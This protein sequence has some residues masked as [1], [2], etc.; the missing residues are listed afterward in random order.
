M[1]SVCMGIV[2]S[3]SV[4]VV[5]VVSV[6]SGSVCV[7][8]VVSESLSLTSQCATAPGAALSDTTH[9]QMPNSKR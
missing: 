7:V 9:L 1:W 2:V 6:V 5:S 3:G 8:S 4:C